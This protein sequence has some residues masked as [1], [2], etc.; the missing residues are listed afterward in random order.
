MRFKRCACGPWWVPKFIRAAMSTQFNEECIQHDL[1]YTEK[2]IPQD[3][4]DTK[5]LIACIK[6]ARG[7]WLVEL[8]AVTY[9]ILVRAGGKF[10][11]EKDK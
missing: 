3:Q 4:A 1:D 10:S 8:W 7:R 6:R 2:K 11:W 9:Y 5:F